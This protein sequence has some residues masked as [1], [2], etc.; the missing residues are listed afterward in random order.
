VHV[1]FIGVNC[2]EFW[3][4]AF[5]HCHR[6]LPVRRGRATSLQQAKPGAVLISPKLG[7]AGGYKESPIELAVED[8]G[9]Q[10]VCVGNGMD[11]LPAWNS[12][13]SWSFVGDV[14]ED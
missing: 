10:L 6:L 8:E 5:D 13:W 1:D 11:N 7:G 12:L 2:R 4:G 3:G 14:C 9:L